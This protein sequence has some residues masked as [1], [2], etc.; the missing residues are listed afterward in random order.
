MIKAVNVTSYR[1]GKL[2]NMCYSRGF[3]ALDTETNEF[4][5]LDGKFPYVLERKKLVQ[6]VIDA[7]WNSWMK[8]IAYT[9]K[10]N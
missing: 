8:R 2:A 1:F 9:G 3:G 6:S 10:A 7:N 5:S 4:L